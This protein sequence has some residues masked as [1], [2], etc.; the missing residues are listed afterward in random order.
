M[1]EYNHK[2]TN[3]GVW[4]TRPLKDQLEILKKYYPI[5]MQLNYLHTDGHELDKPAEDEVCTIVEYVLV[6]S[7][8][9]HLNETWYN[10]SV[11]NDEHTSH[12]LNIAHD[13]KHITFFR[14]TKSELRDEKIKEI[15]S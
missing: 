13:Q 12:K 14:L 2:E 4:N 9:E 11:M 8:N 1:W 6:H 3:G 15:I 7:S 10:L 5:G